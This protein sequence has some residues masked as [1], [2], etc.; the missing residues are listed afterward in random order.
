MGDCFQHNICIYLVPEARGRYTCN[1]VHGSTY[2]YHSAGEWLNSLLLYDSTLWLM[3]RW[4]FVRADEPYSLLI[5]ASYFTSWFEHTC[6]DAHEWLGTIKLTWECYISYSTS[7]SIVF[8]SL[9]STGDLFQCIERYVVFI[10]SDI[11]SI[12]NKNSLFTNHFLYRITLRM[13]NTRV[14]WK[15]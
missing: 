13:T 4:I 11:Y 14:Y 5:H 7:I 9:Y 12:F 2:H 6:C 10:F 3:D 15:D 8:V 1:S